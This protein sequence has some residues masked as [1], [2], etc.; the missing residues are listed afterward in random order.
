MPWTTNFVFTND[1]LMLF[2][3][4]YETFIV[5]WNPQSVVDLYLGNLENF[6]SRSRLVLCIWEEVIST[7]IPPHNLS[8]LVI[9]SAPEASVPRH[10][11]VPPRLQM[12]VN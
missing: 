6:L 12:T 5:S 1:V 8:M 7:S 3:E 4:N 10:I 9:L 2:I 11:P